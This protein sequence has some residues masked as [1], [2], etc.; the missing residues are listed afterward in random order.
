[1]KTL[2]AALLVSLC[3]LAIAGDRTWTVPV[4]RVVDGDT[5]QTKIAV[6]PYPLDTIKIRILNIDTPEK[7]YLAKCEKEAQLGILA[8]KKMV[9]L[10]GPYKE[11]TLKN[12]K[13]DKYGGRVDSIVI[14]NGVDVGA[15]MVELGLAQ[16]Y[17]GT[18]S[19]PNWCK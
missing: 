6:L 16:Y 13:Y 2:I 9:E 19:K 18:G 7:G 8:T 1:M 3:S 14:I 4:V 17:T 12:F 5:I 15:K 10:V 11:M